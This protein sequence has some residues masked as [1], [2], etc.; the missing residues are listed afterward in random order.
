MNVAGC[1][2]LGLLVSSGPRARLMLGVGFCGGLTTFS[3]FSFEVASLLDDGEPF[4]AAGYVGLSL[5]LGVAAFV[6]ARR[7]VVRD[8]GP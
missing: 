8:A 6:S 2:G 5:V 3:T 1:L 4:R 7:V